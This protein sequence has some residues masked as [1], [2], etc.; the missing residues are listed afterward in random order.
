MSK[1]SAADPDRR[2]EI[3]AAADRVFYRDGF[4]SVGIDQIA[5]EADV[6]LA[7]LYRHFR[8]RTDL[9]VSA[10]GHREQ[11]FFVFLERSAQGLEGAARVLDLFAG[12]RAWAARQT[13]NGC[14]FHRAASAHPHEAAVRAVALAHKRAYLA[15]VRRRLL[16]G[17]WSDTQAEQLA[18][19]LFLLLEGVVASAGVLGDGATDEAVEMAR[20]LLRA[21]R[22]QRPARA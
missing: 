7:T 2:A 15:L 4:A 5:G 8:G 22:R 19:S 9:V 13:G 21:T 11:Q 14:L 17:G 16:E 1:G 20:T 6:A 10:L 18:P 12:L 3:A